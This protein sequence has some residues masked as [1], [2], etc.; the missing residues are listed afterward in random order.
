MPHQNIFKIV[1]PAGIILVLG[2]LANAIPAQAQ[3]A[4]LQIF[5]LDLKFGSQNQQVAVLQQ[6]LNKLGPEIYPEG[7]VSSYFGPL[8]QAAVKRFQ[9][10][11]ASEILTPA[12]VDAP[13]GFVGTY[14]RAK[15]NKVYIQFYFKK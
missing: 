13:T 10:K 1:V 2:L 9:A 8:T 6:L 3:T 5:T 12:G 7:L 15:L 14:T 4:T 11:Y